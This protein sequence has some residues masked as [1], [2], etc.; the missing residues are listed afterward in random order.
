VKIAVH[1]LK[2]EVVGD[3]EL[4][5]S[6]FDVPFREAV[7]HQAVVCLLA[8]RRQGTA[9]TKTRGQVSGSTRKLY[10]QKGTGRARRG[11]IKSPLVRGGGVVFGPSPRS[12]RQ[13]LPRKMK[14]LAF[15]CALSM[16]MREGDVW[17]V[18]DIPAEQPRTKDI[19]ALLGSAGKPGSALIVTP[20][21]QPVL[22]L[23]AR[24]L[25]GAR[26]QTCATLS[27]L[28]VMT[29]GKLIATVS[30]LRKMETIWGSEGGNDESA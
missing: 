24:N 25:R 4:Q 28:D 16:K 6:V 12:Y 11:S 13:R 9:A 29:S 5:D 27:T 20:E 15:K 26:V 19:V 22:A 23:S 7:V 3:V 1:N 21:A 2:G 17:V 8:N 14:R 30:A 10:A 18:E